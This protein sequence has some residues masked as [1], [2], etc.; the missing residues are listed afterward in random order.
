MKP[1]R[2]RYL[3]IEMPDEMATIDFM[4]FCT[5]TLTVEQA[6]DDKPASI[7]VQIK[8][9][10]DRVTIVEDKSYDLPESES[11]PDA[12]EYSFVVP[13]IDPCECPNCGA[14]LKAKDNVTVRSA[15]SGLSFTTNIGSG[16]FEGCIM[17]ANQEDATLVLIDQEPEFTC[18]TCTERLDPDANEE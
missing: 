4:G 5:V 14:D 3:S 11:D 13:Y 7:R 10:D 9:E 6:T 15:L 2:G 17:D 8:G 1:E 18:T 16:E 12:K